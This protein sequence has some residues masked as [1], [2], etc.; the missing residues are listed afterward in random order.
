MALK[1]KTEYVCQN[2]GTKSGK[3]MG[4]CLGCGEW[5]TLQE[6]S[7]IPISKRE[8]KG[9]QTLTSEKVMSLNDISLEQTPRFQTRVQE[10]DRV[11]GGGIV[12]GSL[13]LLG[14]DPGIGKSTL[15][16][17]TMN[18]LFENNVS[19]L[20]VT[21]EESKEQIKMRAVRL[22][23]T[24]NIQM[25]AE[26]S[27][28][29][30][31]AQVEKIK[32]QVL[33]VDSIQ[34]LFL[35]HLDSAPGSVSQVRECAAKLLYLSK[36]SGTST[37]L[38]GHV[39][40]EG[41]IAGPRIL[42]HMV[43]TVLYFEGENSGQ[44]RILRTIKNRYGS[45]HEIGVFEMTT[46]GLKEITNP[47]QVFLGQ[48]S[49]ETPGSC[50]TATLSG[51]RPVLT[52]I[53]SLVSGSHLAQ[54]RRTVIGLDSGRMALIIAVIEKYLGLHFYNQDVY[55]SVTGGLRLMEPG[56]DVAIL[57]SLISSFRNQTLS[58][59][60]M[61]FGEIG[62]TGELRPASFAEIRIQ[63]A[64]KLGYKTILLPKSCKIDT[65]DIKAEVLTFAHVSE[66]FSEIF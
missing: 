26:N 8:A 15:I 7:I 51:T 4:K 21:G 38:I 25:L 17:Q 35:N 19:V 40:K 59:Y 2:C 63:E 45:T 52:E 14:G 23:I 57:L 53:Q 12:P 55:A 61:A 3:W 41:A 1:N 49:R 48:K 39:T 11:L 56:C 58:G 62:L 34:T 32:P 54:P 28:D 24:G 13:V 29:R 50:V 9:F 42:E 37:I 30:I 16:L 10:L 5:N 36:S 64:I 20:Y 6:E 33:V 46:K 22:G 27:L 65:K 47:S 31:I 60:L 43:D 66:L 18:H 44:F